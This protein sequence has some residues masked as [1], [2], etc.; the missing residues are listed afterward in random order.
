MWPFKR[1][2]PP[3]RI[4][5]SPQPL[6]W[7]PQ[8]YFAL[9]GQQPMPR[10]SDFSGQPLTVPG[11]ILG[12]RT[13]HLAGDR[14]Y[15]P[16]RAFFVWK[17]GENV[18][19]CS[20][21]GYGITGCA[22]FAHCKCGFY[23]YTNGSNIYYGPDRAAQMWFGDEP[24]VRVATLVEGYGKVVTGSKG[25]RAQKMRILAMAMEEEKNILK[26]WPTLAPFGVP[27]YHTQDAML[28]EH[29]L[30]EQP[31]KSAPP[32]PKPQIRAS[33]VAR[34]LGPVHNH[35]P[36]AVDAAYCRQ[37]KVK[38]KGEWVTRGDCLNDDGTG[39]DE[40]F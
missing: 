15:S 9:L 32:F 4:P 6:N 19:I 3:P 38:F 26:S 30:P 27:V 29:P 33:Q 28:K 11:T 22:D 24:A 16:S 39:K 20:L 8:A 37:R 10:E 5:R 1:K 14:L 40:I 13:L 12:L 36:F 35:G 7:N 18:S 17:P 21:T 2:P 34:G 23:A 31:K 25:F